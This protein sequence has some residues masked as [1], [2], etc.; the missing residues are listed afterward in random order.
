MTVPTQ[1]H[2]DEPK[3]ISLK[4]LLRSKLVAE[5]GLSVVKSFIEPPK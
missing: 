5:V 4:L 3:K 2:G 1:L